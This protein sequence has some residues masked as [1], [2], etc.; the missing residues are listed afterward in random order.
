[1]MKKVL[2]A[3]ETIEREEPWYMF[4]VGNLSLNNK[5]RGCR[6]QSQA[7]LNVEWS[8]QLESSGTTDGLEF[9][10]EFELSRILDS[11][12]DVFS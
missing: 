10:I 1:M 6:T 8:P 12:E 9:D 11:D 5:T 2:D 4:R 3:V 7:S